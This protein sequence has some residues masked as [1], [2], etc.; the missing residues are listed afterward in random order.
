MVKPAQDKPKS[1]LLAASNQL[2]QAVGA[3]RVDID[4]V[5]QVQ[6]QRDAGPALRQP[7][8]QL[9]GAKKKCPVQ[10]EDGDLSLL[11]LQQR[12]LLRV[13]TLA[14]RQARNAVD[15]RDAGGEQADLDRHRQ[16]DHHRQDEDRQQADAVG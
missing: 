7:V 8:D 15:E 11:S 1:L 12:S 2:Q 5:L 10:A 16:V 14:A 3:R 9:G 6:H 4:D 13:H